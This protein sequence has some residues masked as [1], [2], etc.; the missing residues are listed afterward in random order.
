MA[1]LVQLELDE[2]DKE[3]FQE[4]QNSMAEAQR[5]MHGIALKIRT[6]N[7]ESKH[8]A[9]TLVE[10]EPLEEGTK[11]YEQVGK[12]FLLKPLAQL[13][14]QFVESVKASDAEVAALTD[15]KAHVEKVRC[16]LLTMRCVAAIS[17][18][19]SGS[20]C[21]QPV[22]PRTQAFEKVKEDFQ[23]FVKAHAVEA[24]EEGE[25]NAEKK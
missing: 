1:E 18:Y 11:T 22:A 23:E 8:A 12:M 9:L 15:K 14:E 20:C 13:R 25:G 19:A 24:K 10:M 2:K 16:R 3:N 21:R 5:E 17:P 6:K 7:A 4:L